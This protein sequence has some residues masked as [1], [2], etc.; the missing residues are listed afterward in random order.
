M[1]PEPHRG[2]SRLS[3]MQSGPVRGVSGVSFVPLLIPCLPGHRSPPAQLAQE[4]PTRLARGKVLFVTGFLS[5]GLILLCFFLI[6]VHSSDSLWHS[7]CT[8][9]PAPAQLPCSTFPRPGP[10]V[11]GGAMQQPRLQ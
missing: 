10:A 9:I 3:P 5:F 7:L 1:T 6:L 4:H 11:A 8:R 2:L